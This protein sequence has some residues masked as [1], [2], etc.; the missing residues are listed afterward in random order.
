MDPGEIWR[1]R[2]GLCVSRRVPKGP[3]G[4]RRVKKYIM[5]LHLSRMVLIGPGGSMRMQEGV[6]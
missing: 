3:G 5:D 6:V 1:V 4:S 2:E